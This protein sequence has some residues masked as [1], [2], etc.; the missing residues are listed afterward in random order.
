MNPLPCCDWAI[1][2]ATSPYLAAARPARVNLLCRPF[3]RARRRPSRTCRRGDRCRRF[4]L[5]EFRI[6]LEP[7]LVRSAALV[8]AAVA[9]S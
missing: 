7:P 9:L 3:A 8:T 5:R 4:L 6:R 1:V 2:S